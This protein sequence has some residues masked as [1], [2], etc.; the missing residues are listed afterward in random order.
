[1]KI[2]RAQDVAK[3]MRSLTTAN[4]W[5]SVYVKICTHKWKELEKA[6]HNIIKLVAKKKQVKNSEFYVIEP[7]KAKQIMMEF[8]RLIDKDDF[9]ISTGCV[10]AAV[11]ATTK[12]GK[13]SKA[14]KKNSA[15]NPKSAQTGAGQYR[16]MSAIVVRSLMRHLFAKGLIKA[17]DIKMFTDAS[18]HLQFKIGSASICT[19]MVDHAK[20]ARKIGGAIR[21][22]PEKFTFRKKDYALCSQLYPRSVAKFLDMALKHGLTEDD[23]AKLC[24]DPTVAKKF[25]AEIRAGK[26][27]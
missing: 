17:S 27:K 25:F 2:G 13:P 18:S 14:G 10:N 19:V 22:Y 11:T 1:V 9:E 5:L 15:N 12:P 8:S 6:T 7:E 24:P 21:Y 20:A 23:V 26:L 3:R 4:P 16:G